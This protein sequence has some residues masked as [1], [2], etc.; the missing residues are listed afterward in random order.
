MRADG[1]DLRRVLRWLTYLCLGYLFVLP[2]GHNYVLIPVIGL[3]AVVSLVRVVLDRRW[4]PIQLLSILGLVL[5]IGLLGTVVGIGNAGLINGIAVWLLAPLVFFTF[6]FSGDET[7]VRGII[8]TSAIATVGMSIIMIVYSAGDAGYV[9]QFIPDGVADVLNARHDRDPVGNITIAFYGLSTFVAATPMW[10]TAMFLPSHPLLPPRWLSIT[11]AGLAVIVMLLAG[12]SALVL[13]VFVVPAIIWILLQ[14]VRGRQARSIKNVILP[15]GA[16]AVAG[17]TVGVLALSGN[18]LVLR[19]W[20]RI[21]GFL[22]GQSQTLDD[23]VR[24]EQIEELLAAWSQSPIFGHG[25]G[26]VIEGYSRSDDRPWNFEMQYHLLLFQVGI[27]GLAL[28]LAA[29][30]I[31]IRCFVQALRERRDLTP[32]LLFTA[33][34]A[35]AM[36]IANG[37][38]P[39]LQ[40]PGHMWA[41]YLMLMVVSIALRPREEVGFAVQVDRTVDFQSSAHTE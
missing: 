41:I 9:P 40:A 14:I 3:L 37:T 36:T 35:L 24:A 19:T 1:I 12:R 15:I 28:L 27:V 34:A 7:V 17:A 26:A 32:V 38:N 29:A 33:A 20:D 31:A 25:F 2:V 23:R 5:C 16:V 11:T 22:T 8:R 18:T 21:A 30:G 6:A 39:Y 13:V 10:L 4:P